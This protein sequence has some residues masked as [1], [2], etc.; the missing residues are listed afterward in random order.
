[1]PRPRMWLSASLT[2]PIR[3]PSPVYGYQN[4]EMAKKYKRLERPLSPEDTFKLQEK[5]FGF[6]TWR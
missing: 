4:K 1:M 2:D 5:I 3:V 6:L